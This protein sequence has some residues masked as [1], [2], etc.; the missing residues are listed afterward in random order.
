MLFL[1]GLVSFFWYL[2]SG[3]PQSHR[4][5]TE[6]TQVARKD[7]E[8][9]RDTL[10]NIFER[11]GGFFGRLEIYTEVLTMKAMKDIMAKIM[12]EVLRIFTIATAETKQGRTSESIP[13]D[14]L[15]RSRRFRDSYQEV[16]WR[17]RYRGRSEKTG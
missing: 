7:A 16:D 8:L 12:V 4:S 17:V 5:D 15:P 14:K 13:R 6:L 11:I 3:S 1:L 9:I 2:W 10:I